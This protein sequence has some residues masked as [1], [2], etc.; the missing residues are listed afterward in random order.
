MFGRKTPEERAY[1]AKRKT[2]GGAP[3]C[4][5]CD[6]SGWN[7]DTFDGCN[8]CYSTGIDPGPRL[9]PRIAKKR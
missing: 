6:G 4:D 7:G 8:S 3:P 1:A 9:G 2:F 5:D